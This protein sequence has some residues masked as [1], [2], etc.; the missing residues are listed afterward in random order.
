[1]PNKKLALRKKVKREAEKKQQALKRRDMA[2]EERKR[3]TIEYRVN[4]YMKARQTPHRNVTEDG[5]DTIFSKQLT[6]DQILARLNRNLEILKALE[7]E[8]DKEMA[9]RQGMN[10]ELEEDGCSTLKEKI[11]ALQGMVLEDQKSKGKGDFAFGG[12]AEVVFTPFNEEKP[13]LC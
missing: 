3:R 12:E 6:K 1:M 8:Y 7:E 9:A 10:S 5:S 4:D 13:E 2:I 11:E